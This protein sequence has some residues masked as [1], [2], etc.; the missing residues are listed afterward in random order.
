M[1]AQLERLAF[2]LECSADGAAAKVERTTALYER[3]VDEQG[4]VTTM[5]L[6][7]ILLTFGADGIGPNA[8]RA[9]EVFER[10]VKIGRKSMALC[11]RDTLTKESRTG[12]ERNRD[13]ATELLQMA[14]DEDGMTGA[15]VAL[16]EMLPYGM[17]GV[18]RDVDRAVLLYKRAMEKYYGANV[19]AKLAA[20][21]SCV[22][23]AREN[24]EKW[25]SVSI[26][27]FPPSQEHHITKKSAM[28]SVI[29]SCPYGG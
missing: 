24:R 27:I 8:R 2:L 7:R 6:L 14:I 29:G 1:A 4:N 12:A 15:M 17:D 10:A 23:G 16:G 22:G 25:M 5:V 21:Q 19:V 28:D 20:L 18:K 9:T 13:R 11:Y 3:V 26:L